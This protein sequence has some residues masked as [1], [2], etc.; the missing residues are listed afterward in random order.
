MTDVLWQRMRRSRPFDLQEGPLVFAR[1]AVDE[2]KDITEEGWRPHA[3]V[4]LY[5]ADLTLRQYD[6]PAAR[7]I[8]LTLLSVGILLFLIPT[9][10]SV[11]S[12]IRGELTV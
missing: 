10:A 8:A 3:S 4:G 6:R 7:V 9:V 5:H 12:V 2:T 11:I 1:S